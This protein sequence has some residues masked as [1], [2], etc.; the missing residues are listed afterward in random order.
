MWP[1]RNP[2][3]AHP[4]SPSSC[5]AAVLLLE[6]PPFSLLCF[7]VCVFQVFSSSLFFFVFPCFVLLYFFCVPQCDAAQ[8]IS[9]SLFLSAS[10][11]CTLDIPFAPFLA[12]NAHRVRRLL[13]SCSL[14]RLLAALHVSS[15]F[16]LPFRLSSIPVS[17][18]VTASGAAS[19]LPDRDD[20][21]NDDGGEGRLAAQVRSCHRDR[22]A[23]TAAA[24]FRYLPFSP[25][26]V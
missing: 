3:S 22:A 15:A 4:C 5:P 14:S 21:H 9:P 16:F 6:A 25:C 23:H 8:R 1:L 11:S 26:I 13:G 24:A 10:W 7:C 18:L 17:P 2:P 20:N 12:V 19:P